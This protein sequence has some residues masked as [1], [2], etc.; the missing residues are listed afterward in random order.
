M[1]PRSGYYH[2]EANAKSG[3][4]ANFALQANSSVIVPGN[5]H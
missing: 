5:T 4:T 1:T 3:I 2:P